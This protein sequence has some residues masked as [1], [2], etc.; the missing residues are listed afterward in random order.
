VNGRRLGAASAGLFAASMVANLSMVVYYRVLS[1][2]LGSAYSQLWA[3]MGVLSVLANVT[4]GLNTYLVKAFSADLERTGPGAV[5]GRL[6]RL[7]KPGFISLG[8]FAA[9]LALLSPLLASYL[10]LPGLGLVLM[11]D[12]LFTLGVLLLALRS[13]QQGLHHFGWLGLSQGGEGLACVGM[14]CCGPVT[15]VAGG[16]SARLLGQGVGVLC[17]LGGL[18]G[19]G[20]A[21]PP[22]AV[23]GKGRDL[24]GALFEGGSDTLALTLLALLCYL[25]VVVLKHY[26]S[27]DRAGLYSRAALVAKS[28]LFLPGALNIVLLAAA[29][30]EL[31]GGR[32]PRRLLRFFLL[33]ALALDLAGLAVVWNC[34]SFCMGLL[35]GPDPRFRTDAML[36]LTRWFSLAVIPLGLLQMVVVY[37]LA[38][39]RKGVAWGLGGLALGYLVLLSLVKDSELAVV[40]SLG[41]C[42]LAGLAGALWVALARPPLAAAAA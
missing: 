5:K 39:R 27:D 32:D 9:L 36:A 14:V 7:L 25:D 3:L 40:A 16:L 10:K 29:A 31:A 4:L 35:A 28:F 22:A 21:R 20:P 15:S 18:L 26:Y 24:R 1:D 12:A 19:L 23:P 11:M 42:S 8:A 30:R 17:A 33:G 38:I 37:L 13:A 2:R 34:T 6:L 41:A